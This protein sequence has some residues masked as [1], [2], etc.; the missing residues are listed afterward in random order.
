MKKNTGFT[1]LELLVVI[2]IIAVI[3]GMG[4]VS[5]SAT[6]KRGRDAKRKADLVAIQAALEQYY[7][8]NSYVYPSTCTDAASFLATAWPVDP[9]GA[10]YVGT[11]SSTGYC[12]CTPILL[13]GG[14]TAGNSNNSSCD[15]VNSG[16]YYCVKNLQ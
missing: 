10:D 16:S 2:G 4:I 3:I 14:N 13:E 12:L 9:S 7:S 8:Q 5:Y 6:Q 1:L 11:C 15:M